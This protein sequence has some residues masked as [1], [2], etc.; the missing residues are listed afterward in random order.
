[1]VVVMETLLVFEQPSSVCREKRKMKVTENVYLLECTKRSHVYLITAEDNILIDTGM[2]G[3]GEKI[4]EELRGLGVAPNSIRTIL[5]THHDVDHV[6]NAKQLVKATGGELWAPPEDVPY[7]IGEKTRPGVKRIIQ[8]VIRPQKPAA[9][10][11]YSINQRFGEV[12][13]IRAPGHT[14]GHTVFA[15]RNVLF[16][17]DLFRVIKGRFRLLPKFMTWDRNELKKS[18]SLIQGL[19]F[20]WLC[21]SHGEPIQNGAP[22][23]FSSR[24]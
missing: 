7:I 3:L 9:P 11:C 15:Y 13:A 8:A 1:M 5:L 24:P 2:P 16:T 4:L 21:P 18:I 19:E 10:R 6:G 17:G 23:L 22:C 20:E 14:P 12:S